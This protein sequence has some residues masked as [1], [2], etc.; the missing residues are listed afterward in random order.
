MHFLQVDFKLMYK[1]LT[2]LIFQQP[3][4]EGRRLS[5]LIYFISSPRGYSDGQAC[6]AGCGGIRK[7]NRIELRSGAESGAGRFTKWQTVSLK[8]KAA[9]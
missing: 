1:N 4:P 8:A 3:V 9:A 5:G 7:A 6:L 2:L